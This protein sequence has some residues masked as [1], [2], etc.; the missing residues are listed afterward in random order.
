LL[1]SSHDGRHLLLHLHGLLMMISFWY[2][3]LSR[4]GC[5]V[6]H[7]QTAALSGSGTAAGAA[8][9]ARRHL[10]SGVSYLQPGPLEHRPPRPRPFAH[11][12]GVGSE[13]GRSAATG[14]PHS[15]ASTGCGWVSR[16]L[17]AGAAVVGWPALRRPC[18]HHHPALARRTRL[19]CPSCCTPRRASPRPDRRVFYADVPHRRPCRL[20]LQSPPAARPR[21]HP[22]FYRSD[23]P[24]ASRLLDDPP[25]RAPPPVG[26]AAEGGWTRWCEGASL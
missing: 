26:A 9:E 6:R 2:Y 5:C 10:G 18:H 20:L 25:C 1:V 19:P 14:Q 22:R 12:A 13:L 24:E 23:Q 16:I 8:A 7:S 21:L 4:R 17:L 11:A 3:T 15:L